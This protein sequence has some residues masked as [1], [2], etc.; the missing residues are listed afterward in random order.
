TRVY[1]GH[2]Y[3]LANLRFCLHIEPDNEVTVQRMRD[4]QAAVDAG[5]PTLPSTIGL[6]LATN[7]FLRT[8]HASVQRITHPDAAGSVDPVD[9]LHVLRQMKNSF[10]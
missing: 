9:V 6:E 8:T 3:T 2:E 5:K 10:S 1:C 7:V 4:A